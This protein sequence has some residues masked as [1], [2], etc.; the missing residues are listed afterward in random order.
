MHEGR[1]IN[2]MPR[3]C[4]GHR[5]EPI[6]RNDMESCTSSRR[7][8]LTLRSNHA[9]RSSSDPEPHVVVIRAL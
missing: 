1:D 8:H 9:Y 5:E 4:M 2:Q 3:H 6:S 7:T